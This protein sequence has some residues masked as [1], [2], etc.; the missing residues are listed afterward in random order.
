[1]EQIQTKQHKKPINLHKIYL[2]IIGVLL[3]Y[4]IYSSGLFAVQI[5]EKNIVISFD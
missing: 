3:A 1:M 2:P 4:S 5:V